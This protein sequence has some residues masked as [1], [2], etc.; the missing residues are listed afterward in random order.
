M[1]QGCPRGEQAAFGRHGTAVLRDD[2]QDRDWGDPVWIA[3]KNP[4]I[5]PKRAAQLVVDKVPG[6][7]GG[8]A[9]AIFAILG[10]ERTV[11]A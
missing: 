2:E 10:G 4:D 1:V 7:F 5:R 3:V 8:L 9:T 11:F 6:A